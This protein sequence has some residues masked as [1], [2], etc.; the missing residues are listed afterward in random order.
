MGDDAVGIVPAGG[1]ADLGDRLQQAFRDLEDVGDAVDEEAIVLSSISAT[2]MAL[3][4]VGVVL[5]LP[6]RVAMPSLVARSM[7]GITVPRR[8]SRRTHL[9]GQTGSGWPAPIRDY[10][11]WSSCGGRTPARAA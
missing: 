6:G 4:G 9:P 5:F 3:R 10:R 8:S 11:G 7:T 1:Y 2:T